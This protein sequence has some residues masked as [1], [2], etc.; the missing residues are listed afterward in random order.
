MTTLSHRAWISSH[1]Y[2]SVIDSLIRPWRPN[3]QFAS[4]KKRIRFTTNSFEGTRAL[5]A[6]IVIVNG[7]EDDDTRAQTKIF[8]DAKSSQ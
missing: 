7:D 3:Y 8:E 1:D 5:K 4:F 2:L 6:A